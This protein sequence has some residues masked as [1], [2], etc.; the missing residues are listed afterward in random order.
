M[1][2]KEEPVPA[3]MILDLIAKMWIGR[4]WE[5]LPE[6]LHQ[7]KR[8]LD[9][10]FMHLGLASNRQTLR[11]LNS[12][13]HSLASAAQVYVANDWMHTRWLT[14][15][16][17]RAMLLDIDSAL[18]D[19]ARRAT[20]YALVLGAAAGILGSFA[21]TKTFSLVLFVAICLGV[22]SAVWAAFLRSELDRIIAEVDA[23]LYFGPVLAE[24]LE[25]LNRLRLQVPS[26]LIAVLRVPTS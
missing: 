15:L 17:A 26:I 18:K 3:S 11:G 5:R 16:I 8:A 19:R 24:R 14:D 10:V 22:A 2:A 7:R 13:M 9:Q 21:V 12:R 6:P 20:I 25:H 4:N 23:S 1:L